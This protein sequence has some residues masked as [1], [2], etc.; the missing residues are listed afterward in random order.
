MNNTIARCRAYLSAHKRGA[1][2]TA[3]AAAVLVVVLSAVLFLRT[4]REQE[5]IDGY[6][7]SVME[8]DFDRFYSLYHPDVTGK[9]ME[10]FNITKDEWR[11]QFVERLGTFYKNEEKAGNQSEV[12]WKMT[13]ER[14]EITGEELTTLNKRYR[15]QFDVQAEEVQVVE[16]HQTISTT[17]KRIDDT[18]QIVTKKFVSNNNWNVRMM[19]IDGEWYL[20]PLEPIYYPFL[21]DDRDLFFGKGGTMI[22]LE[23]TDYWGTDAQ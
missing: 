20:D 7:K 18:G 3:V 11:P 10:K 8:Q 6:Y 22:R 14:W 17:A 9:C 12:T 19:K 21:D 23:D 16:V 15:R 13:G 2:L 4:S 1:I 5:L